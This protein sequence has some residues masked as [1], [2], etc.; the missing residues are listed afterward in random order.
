V[1]RSTAGDGESEVKSGSREARGMKLPRMR[2]P[3]WRM[4]VVIAIVACTIGAVI[5]FSSE[6]NTAQNVIFG[7]AAFYSLPGLVIVAR[8]VPLLKV[9]KIAGKIAVF[10]AP[11]AGLF[12]L[13][14]LAMSGYV[15]FVGGFVLA[16]LVI[17]WVALLAVGLFCEGS[18]AE[19]V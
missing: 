10:G 1:A 14:G 5:S 19:G 15:G 13:L 3:L 6:A 4:M 7:W 8:G 11:L 2:F 9:V 17:G 18:G 12:G 16:A